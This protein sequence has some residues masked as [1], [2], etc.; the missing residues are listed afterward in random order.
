MKLYVHGIKNEFIEK[1]IQF[2]GI[3]NSFNIKKNP[4]LLNIFRSLI[5]TQLHYTFLNLGMVLIIFCAVPYSNAYEKL[6]F[7]V[8]EEGKK[9]FNIFIIR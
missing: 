2:R 6:S 3:I 5:D 7:S 4:F 1:L 8:L 9:L